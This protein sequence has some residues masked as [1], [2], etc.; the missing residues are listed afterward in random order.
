MAS[1]TVHVLVLYWH[2]ESPRT[3]RA[4]IRH[5]LRALESSGMKYKILYYNAVHGAPV[6]LRHLHF[7][8]VILHTTLLCLRWSHQFYMWKWK[9]AWIRDL[10]CVKV[11]MPQDEYDHSEILDEWLYEWEVSEIFTIFKEDV[12]KVLYPLMCD[13]AD[14]YECF[15]G[16]I[17]ESI[18]KRYLQSLLPIDLRPYDIVYRATHLPYWFG[19][20]G[21]LKHRIANVMGRRALELGLKCDISTSVDDTIVGD[22]WLNFLASG[23]AV[24]GCE[25]GSSVLDRRGE[26]RAKIQAMLRHNPT[27]SFEEVSSQLPVDWDDYRFFA[28]SPRHFEAVMT[29]TCQ[30]LVDGPYDGVLEADKHYIPLRRDFSNIDEFLDKVRDQRLVESIVERAYSDIYLSGRY[31]Y[32]RLALSVD[33]ALHKKRRPQQLSVGFG[34]KVIWPLGRVAGGLAIWRL[35]VE[36]VLRNLITRKMQSMR[37]ILTA[38]RQARG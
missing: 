37:S 7:D 13:K 26:V 20:H 34:R 5:H 4:A 38:Y 33:R 17:D 18:A 31:T 30:I 6:W 35:K 36:A 14:F 8:A 24:V 19:S 11:A 29:K 21:Q 1:S 28:I 9:L 12:R 32:Q 25:S 2:P 10:E 3:M 27:M 16:Y 22:R 23:R 15:T